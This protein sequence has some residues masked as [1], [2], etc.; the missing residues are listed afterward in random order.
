[1]K[2]IFALLWQITIPI[3]WLLSVLAI[4]CA[5][6]QLGFVLPP[7]V[8]QSYPYPLVGVILMSIVTAI[9]S[10][11]LYLILRPHKFDWSLRRVVIAFGIFLTL[12]I[13][14]IYTTV[15][16][17]PGYV[18]IPGDFTLLLTFLL[19]ILLIVTASMAVVKRLSKKVLAG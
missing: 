3:L 1:M 8:G 16:D 10:A 11:F 18:Y 5:G 13:V 14:V 7:P 6:F 19:F 9:E 17:L 4:V 12:S 15:T 2:K